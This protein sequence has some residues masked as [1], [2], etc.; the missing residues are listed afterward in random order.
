[1]VDG[2]DVV[3]NPEG[4]RKKINMISGGEHSGYGI[5][6]LRENLW[7]FSQFYGVTNQVA[8]ERIDSMIKILGLEEFSKT[9]IG[10]LSTGMRQKMNVIRGFVTDP[11]IIFL[12]EPTLGLDVQ[13]S[14]DV[15]K[16]IK[17]W[18]S[19]NKEKTALLTTHYMAE[20]DELC[21]RVAIIDHGKV[22]ACDTPYNL[23]RQLVKDAI[24]HIEVNL[25]L[26]GLEKFK[27][28]PGVKQFAFEHKN[29]V[30]RTK[31]TFILEN[32]SAISNV[33]QGISSEDSKI[34]TLSKAEPTLEDVF[35]YL[36]GRGL[37][38]EGS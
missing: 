25:M 38:N 3:K 14:R 13:V 9:K 16:Y 28:I 27:Q 17:S 26:S 37:E 7:M 34:I 30:N 23:K 19:E 24:Y 5:L 12:D 21:N 4:V 10:K 8:Y 31:L 29:D 33:T 11:K 6:N 36:V 35:V 32:D 20:A 18:M 15:R 22:V 2:I 1:M